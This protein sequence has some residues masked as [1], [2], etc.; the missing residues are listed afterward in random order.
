MI[1]IAAITPEIHTADCD[2]NAGTIIESA[3]E[4]YKKGCDIAVFPPFVITGCTCGSLFKTGT[5]RL[6]VTDSLARIKAASREFKDMLLAVGFPLDDEGCIALIGNGEIYRIISQGR[7]MTLTIG[8]EQFSAVPSDCEMEIGGLNA[9][10]IM[11]SKVVSGALSND[12]FLAGANG[13]IS[14]YSD[15]VFLLWSGEMYAGCRDEYLSRLSEISE[16]HNTCVVGVSSGP[17]ESV[18]ECVYCGLKCVIQGGKVTDSTSK[19][20][21]WIFDHNPEEPLKGRKINYIESYS[22]LPADED[23]SIEACLDIMRIQAYALGER[24]KFLHMKK[25]VLGLS[26]G[27]DSTLALVAAVNAFDRY[28]LDRKDI[29]CVTMPCFGTS[30]K[31]KGNA[32]RLAKAFGVTLTEIDIKDQVCAHLRSIGQPVITGEDGTETFKSDITFENAQARTR[33]MILMDIANKENAIVIGTG[34]MSELALGW[35]TYNGDHMSNFSVN[36]GVP[37]TVIAPVL[38]TYVSCVADRADKEL[39]SEII[40]DIIETPVSPEL[41]PVGKDDTIIQKTED[42]L[43]PYALHDFFLYHMLYCTYESIEQIAGYACRKFEGNY[44]RETVEETLK[45]FIKRFFNNQFK[46]SCMPVGPKVF[47]CSLS[48]RSGFLMPSDAYS[49]AWMRRQDVLS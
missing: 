27:L 10:F 8:D 46:R 7:I 29:L 9:A 31:T 12:D 34:D 45:I 49:D 28:L 40:E 20:G 33:T 42:S 26:G 2:Y 6:S 18:D 5:L 22:F 17:G 3:G 23:K 16:S 13:K 48:P 43:G 37:K 4:A 36:A 11:P 38:R 47:K 14:E 21:I 19:K 32:H 24:L 41:L 30:A 1:R 15:L 39:I 44:S 35:C 25:A